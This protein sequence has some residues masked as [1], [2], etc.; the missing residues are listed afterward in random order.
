MSSYEEQASVFFYLPERYKDLQKLEKFLFLRLSFPKSK[1][2]Y[3]MYQLRL[4]AEEVSYHI[5]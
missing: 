3:V 2:R 1:D 5:K 4:P